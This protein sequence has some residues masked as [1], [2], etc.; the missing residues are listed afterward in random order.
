MVERQ[1]HDETMTDLLLNRF[2]LLVLVFLAL[3][4]GQQ[5][6]A[7]V[8][9][10]DSIGII[11][12]MVARKDTMVSY[13][14]PMDLPRRPVMERPIDSVLMYGKYSSRFRKE[15]YNLLIRQGTRDTVKKW[16]PINNAGMAAMDGRIIRH[17]DFTKVDIFAPVVTDTGYVSHDWLETS[18][19][20]LHRDTRNKI[21]K[22]HLLMKP[23]DPL[24]VFLTAE[25]ERL[26][27]NLSFIMDARFLALP[28]Y[29]TD[30]VDLLLLTQD[31]IPLGLEAEMTKAT[32]AVLGFS[33]QNVLGFGHQLEAT[34]YWDMENKPHV[35]YRLSYGTSNLAGTFASGELEYIHKWNQESYSISFLR[36]FR[37][38]SFKNA[39]GFIFENTKL[40]RNIVLLDTTLL[41]VNL[42]YSITDFWVGRLLP[43]RSSSKWIKSALFLTARINQYENQEDPVS[44]NELLYAY[45]DRTLML[46]STGISHAG[47]RKDKMIYTFGR[48][49][50]VPFGYQ[51][52]IT[53]GYEF[54]QVKD[55]PYLGIG[56]AFGNYFKNST[57][58]WS[59]R[60]SFGSFVNKGLMEQG[61]FRLQ[62]NYISPLYHPNRF[63]FRHL[64]SYFYIHG[65]NRYRGEFVSVENGSGIS[66][67]SSPLMRWND[68]LVLNLETQIF[69]PY[70]LLG[71]RFAFFGK[72]DLGVVTAEKLRMDETRL[73]MGIST[74]VRI[75]N[76]Q[77]VFDNIVIRLG[78]YPG[79]PHDATAS[80]LNIDYLARSRFQDF[81]P[82]KPA[83]VDYR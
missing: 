77:L 53:A 81:L 3:H 35:G 52:Q 30:S 15:L 39:G 47:F 17:I 74:G 29:G 36:D 13:R 59:A 38:T 40:T 79:M 4:A 67:L 31:M 14:V 48:I 50:D 41:N 56:A 69:S 61:A 28:V 27:R 71:F 57:A 58:F 23:G 1:L 26:L 65:I 54:G 24:D 37:S 18:M 34:T 70:K 10:A 11:E 32:L 22:R 21:L 75:R 44:G 76:D 82:S 42:D 25:N 62:A 33:N 9:D 2:V 7:Q 73:F 45:Q 20:S 72:F 80:Y 8:N 12:K 83:L 64:I 16:T 46:F 66:G 19:N 6:M 55:R 51:L 68:K 63:H 43:L 60:I 78:I 5:G 49:E